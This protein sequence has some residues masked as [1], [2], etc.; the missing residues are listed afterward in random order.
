MKIALIGYGKMGKAIHKRLEQDNQDTVSLIINSQNINTLTKENLTGIDVA[1]EFSR[2]EHA[3]NNMRICFEAG[4]PVVCGTT[5]WHAQLKEVVTLCTAQQGT[6]LYAS[7]FSVGVNIFFALNEYLAQLMAGQTDYN[8]LLQ[9][10]HHTQKLDAP[11]GT[12]ISLA[13]ALLHKMGARYAQWHLQNNENAPEKSVPIT[14]HRIEN[15]IGTHTVEYHSAIDS[16]E[17]KHTAHSR[18]GFVQGAIVAARW[19]AGKTGVFTMRDV[20]GF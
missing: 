8:V 20:L 9:E 4:V 12:A 19:L 2:P 7:N 6:L 5:G 18:D 14:A 15:V 17:I 13:K 3:I 11:S 1:I 16:I 10:I